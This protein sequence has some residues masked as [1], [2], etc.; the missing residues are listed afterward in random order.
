MDAPPQPL[1]CAPLGH[2]TLE[3]AVHASLLSA[4][5]LVPILPR[6]QPVH[7]IFFASGWKRP[8][9][10]FSQRA[11][12]SKVDACPGRHGEQPRL[13]VALGAEATR[14]PAAQSMHALPLMY[15]PGPH[16]P[17]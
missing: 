9:V 1:R 4:P 15:D 2:V 16:V 7:A 11:A 8:L 12:F 17:Q 3:H 14:S 13:D 6:P 5:T 10:Q